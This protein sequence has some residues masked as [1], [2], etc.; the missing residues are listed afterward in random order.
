HTQVVCRND[1]NPI[2]LVLGRAG[3]SIDLNLVARVDGFQVAEPGVTLPCNS[4]VPALTRQRGPSNM[5]HTELQG[6]R[7]GPLQNGHRNSD[8]WNA[9]AAQNIAF[10]DRAPG[11][12]IG[13]P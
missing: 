13:A 4:N 10:F 7:F 3:Y 1:L 8:S 11:E 6:F 9:D 5:T 12:T 2:D